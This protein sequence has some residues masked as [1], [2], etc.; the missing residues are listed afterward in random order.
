MG[1]QF[2]CRT[3]ESRS[4]SSSPCSSAP[5]S[6]PW[7]RWPR[8]RRRS[9]LRAR[10]SPATRGVPPTQSSPAPRRRPA[11]G[12]WQREQR[13]DE[14][15][16]ANEQ[17]RGNEKQRAAEKE[18][19]NEKEPTGAKERAA[20]TERTSDKERTSNNEPAADTQR[21]GEQKR[22]DDTEPTNET[23]RANAK[24][25]SSEEE[26][27]GGDELA[28][29]QEISGAEELTS[30]Q[31][32]SGGSDSYIIVLNQ[33]PGRG[34]G[35][36]VREEARAVAQEYGLGITHVY[37]AALAGFAAQVPNEAALR[38]LQ[39]DPRVASVEPDRRVE[40]FAD[41]FPLGVD[42]VGADAVRENGLPTQPT[43][44]EGPSRGA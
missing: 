15:E 28:S 14:Q 26:I 33:A 22:G 4:R 19:T 38:R 12:G 20:E 30:S 6:R 11:P 8:P 18:R 27:F 21:S 31:E 37:D 16:P 39:R 40:A 42:R 24:E 7:R 23:K 41:D 13:T 34:Q 36:A 10:R 44:S 32:N 5:S 3:G 1:E 17:E 35:A 29:S 25:R 43:R 9:A 2:S